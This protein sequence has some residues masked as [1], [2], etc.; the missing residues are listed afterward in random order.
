MTDTAI[1][2]AATKETKAE[3]QKDAATFTKSWLEAID[4]AGEEEKDWRKDGQDAIDLYGDDK[5]RKEARFNILFSNTETICPALYNSPPLPDVRRRFGDTDLDGKA[6]ADVLER[7]ISYSADQYGL[8]GTIKAAVL[9]MALPGRGV[10]RIRYEPITSDAPVIDPITQ[11]PVMGPDGQPVTKPQIDYQKCFADHVQWDDF[12][13]GPGKKWSDVPW[14]AFRHYM[15]RD[16]L[17]ALNHT[18]GATIKL[19]ATV[20]GYDKNKSEAPKDLFKRAVV[21]EIHDKESGQQVFIAESEKTRPLWTGEPVVK[22]ENFFPCPEPLYARRRTTTLIPLIPY[23]MYRD[24]AEELNIISRR[25]KALVKVCKWRGI[26]DKAINEALIALGKAQDGEIL[27]A[28]N[29]FKMLEKQGGI[30]KAI[31]LMPLEKLVA[32]IEQLS[33]RFEQIKQEIYEITG[34]ADILRGASNPNE[35]LGAQ[36]IKAQWGSMRISDMQEEVQRY[37]RDLFRMIAEVYAENFEPPIL[38]L[39]TG[40]QLTPQQVQLMRTDVVRTYRIDIETDSTI[41]ADQSQAQQN[42]SN[43]ISGLAQFFTAV[44]PV[45]QAGFMP[46][47][48]AIDMV[49]S[50]SRA[51]KLGREA[52]DALEAWKQ[53]V[54][55]V[56]QPAAAGM[57]PGAPVPQGL[58]AVAAPPV[59]PGQGAFGMKPPIPQPMGR[60]A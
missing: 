17:T 20:D 59:V 42:I 54:T 40:I 37:C 13:R 18:L 60:V 23:E 22:F 58:P 43:F 27:P 36:Q 9:D 33:K 46:P 34:I 14:V 6:V 10:T 47:E 21:W 51:F 41:R 32:V 26:A 15:T 8:H 45:V 55:M 39:M 3:T 53:R 1:A 5:E 7:S 19:D 35:T 38:Q 44:A 52:S 49:V 12:R 16:Q 56:A 50:W 2:T 28:E 48:V 11:Q 24:Q 57:P 29:A 4:L 25:L 31:W 30:D